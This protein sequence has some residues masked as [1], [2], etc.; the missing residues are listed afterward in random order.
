MA[1]KKKSGPPS[2]PKPSK[3]RVRFSTRQLTQHLRELAADYVSIDNEGNPITRGEQL[4]VII[5]EKA[6]GWTETCIKD[7]KQE[8]I[9]HKPEAW[10]I[11][12]VFERMEGKAPAAVPDDK[13]TLTTAD[14]VEEIVKSRINSIAEAVLAVPDSSR[15]VDVP[16]DRADR[17]QR[18]DKESGI[19]GESASDG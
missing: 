19:P 1:R 9:Y 15:P 8:E 2:L 11:A 14:K 10:A 7:E 4:A 18:P 16:K 3:K 12:L 5:W 17:P 6:L 13:G